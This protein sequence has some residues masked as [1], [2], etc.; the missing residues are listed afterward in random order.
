MAHTVIDNKF[1]V[2]TKFLNSL[3]G[4]PGVSLEHMG[5]GEFYAK[6]PLGRVEFDRM[7][8]KDFP[9]QSGRSHLVYDR[10]G[11]TKAAEWLIGQVE[12][13]GKSVRVASDESALRGRLI[14]L[15]HSRPELREHVLPL[16]DKTAG[17]THPDPASTR[18]DI[19]KIMRRVA[20]PRSAAREQLTQMRGDAEKA[21][22]TY[23]M[24]GIEYREERMEVRQ[25]IALID[26][27]IAQL[28]AIN[29][30][31]F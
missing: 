22:R 15:A 9:D 24:A 20:G 21:A 28:D 4:I 18:S 12:S 11:G 16:V 27:A 7:R 2:D 17:W 5:F 29:L 10:D 25:S 6:T 13:R 31:D 14:R 23:S 1:Y 26:R 30:D 19:I 8:G 3:S